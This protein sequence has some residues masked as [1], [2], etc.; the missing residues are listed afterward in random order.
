MCRY[1]HFLGIRLRVPRTLTL[2][3]PFSEA[4]AYPFRS[5][6]PF[7]S[8]PSLLVLP[9]ALRRCIRQNALRML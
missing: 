5:F 6:P 4:E 1:S 9:I 8:N 3:A 2:F 7:I